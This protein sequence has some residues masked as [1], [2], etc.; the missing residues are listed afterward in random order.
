MA[1]T[2]MSMAISLWHIMNVI[3]YAASMLRRK[4]LHTLYTPFLVALVKQRLYLPS[5]GMPCM[6]G[7][8]IVSSAA[9][10]GHFHAWCDKVLTQ[11]L[12][13]QQ[14]TAVSTGYDSNV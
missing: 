8:C 1:Q 12:H 11:Q 10:R 3:Q 9:L 5:T 14:D 7:C 13:L 2:E 4:L 6:G